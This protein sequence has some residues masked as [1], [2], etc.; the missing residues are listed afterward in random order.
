MI[1]PMGTTAPDIV[2]LKAKM[3]ET[4]MAGDFGVIA[5]YAEAAEEEFVAR[6]NLTPVTRLLDVACGTGNTAIPAARAGAAATGREIRPHD[7]ERPRERG[8][9]AG[10]T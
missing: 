4:W 1:S 2:A 10:V 6:L 8:Q 9:Q 5:R 3:R 7:R